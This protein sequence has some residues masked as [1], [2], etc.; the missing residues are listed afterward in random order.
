MDYVTKFCIAVSNVFF[1]DFSGRI[2]EKFQN[3][4][5]YFKIQYLSECGLSQRAVYADRYNETGG[6]E[7]I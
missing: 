2:G 6:L 3:L 1:I 4:K 5:N 7:A